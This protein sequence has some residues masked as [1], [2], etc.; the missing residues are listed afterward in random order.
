MNKL[1]KILLV[2][3]ALIPAVSFAKHST[4]GEAHKAELT[5]EEHRKLNTEY[6]KHHTLDS[7][8]F[9]LFTN[10]ETGTHIGFPL[11]VILWD[12]GLHV[13]MSSAFHAEEGN[14]HGVAESK[15][16]YY[17]IGHHDGKIYSCDEHGTILE[18]VSED[19]D[20]KEVVS[21]IKP[22]DLSITK[23]VF[24]T[25]LICLLMFFLFRSVAKSYKTGLA[26]TGVAK[27][28]EPIILFIRDDI[29]I[30][31]I[32]EKAHKKYMVYLLTV[33]FFI[34]FLNLAGM[35]PLGINVTGNIAVTAGLAIF[36]FLITNFSAK[37]DYWMHIFWMPGV[38]VP[39]KIMLI[40]IELV[41]MIVKPFALMIRLYANMLAGHI[42]LGSLI[43][44]VV[45]FD[46]YLAKGAF[47]GLTFFMNII[48][49]L[50]AALQAYIF[51]M[52]TALYF[53]SAA[54]EHA[55]EEAH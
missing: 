31:N 41:G 42:V 12:D 16:N 7:H 50:V 40:P 13:F 49:L 8:D 54:A 48:E 35:T 55:H 45:Y 23:N 20:G 52:L 14:E 26:P 5:K 19:A 30:P 21:E 22:L 37:K 24:S 29:A 44:V 43:A 15:G 3:V 38:P 10:E 51:T 25:L 17:L 27:F 2:A 1:W 34:W 47:V 18:D 53:G 39:M 33:F 32:G 11:P 6:V 36:T 9:G 28:F 4:E 46:S